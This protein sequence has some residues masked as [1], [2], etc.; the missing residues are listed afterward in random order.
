MV[1]ALLGVLRFFFLFFLF[2]FCTCLFT[3]AAVQNKEAHALFF[4]LVFFSHLEF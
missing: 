4:F 1:E 3:L 2:F